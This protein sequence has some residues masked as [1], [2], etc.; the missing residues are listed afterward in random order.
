MCLLYLDTAW[1]QDPTAQ[2]ELAD[3][4]NK[5][6]HTLRSSGCAAAGAC[7][8]GSSHTPG[9]KSGVAAI[10]EEIEGLMAPG[11]VLAA[12]PGGF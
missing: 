10:L 6:G 5:L 7:L 12:T 2:K 11:A 8:P 4:N 3:L 1:R 9:G